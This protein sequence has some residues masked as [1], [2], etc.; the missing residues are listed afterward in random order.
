[1]EW[2][3]RLGKYLERDTKSIG[4]GPFVS[5]TSTL[6]RAVETA[7][8]AAA[9]QNRSSSE[10]STLSTLARYSQLPDQWS[11]LGLLD[12]GVCHGMQVADVRERMPE[13]YAL[14]RA[15][16]FHYRFPGGESLFDL[17]KRLTDAVLQVRVF[18]SPKVPNNP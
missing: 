12:T 6:P 8:L 2:A 1:M 10:S 7:Q 18:L 3:K 11:S 16:P 4:L 9:A 14:W 15:D 13:Q 17:N 5:M